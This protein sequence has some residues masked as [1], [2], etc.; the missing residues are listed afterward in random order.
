MLWKG[1]VVILGDSGTTGKGSRGRSSPWGRIGRPR[2]RRRQTNRADPTRRFSGSSIGPDGV[3]VVGWQVAQPVRHPTHTNR[4][5][6]KRIVRRAFKSL[7]GGDGA[8]TVFRITSQSGVALRL[9][10]QSKTLR[11]VRGRGVCSAFLEVLGAGVRFGIVPASVRSA[12]KAFVANFVAT[13]I[14]SL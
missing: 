13:F 2:R 5:P 14:D 7:A 10:P 9:P 3:D 6:R 1:G 12:M 4:T 8:F 11:E